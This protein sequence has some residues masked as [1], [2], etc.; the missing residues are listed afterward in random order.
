MSERKEPLPMKHV[1]KGWGSDRDWETVAFVEWGEYQQKVLAKNFP[2]VSIYGDI[3]KFSY[4]QEKDRIGAVD[5]ICGG[6]P[7]QPFSTAGKRKGAQDER[8]LWPEM[9]RIIREVQ[10]AFVVGENVGGILSMDNGDLFESIC[11]NPGS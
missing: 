5:L 4:E 8:H 10:P 6:F 9:L 7:C 2:G 1:P 3:T 11:V